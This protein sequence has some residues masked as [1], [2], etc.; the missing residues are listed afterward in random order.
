MLKVCDP[1][2]PLG[3]VTV[4][5]PLGLTASPPMVNVAVICVELTTVTFVI[6]IASAL[7]LIVVW[8]AMKFVPVS[9]TPTAVPAIPQLGLSP[10]SVGAPAEAELT[11]NVTPLLVPPAVVTLTLCPPTG[12][13]AVMANVAVT[14]VAVATTL[15]TVMPLS[16]L[17]VAPV[18]LVPVSVTVVMV[19]PWFP[20][21]GLMVLSV[22]AGGGG[23]FTVSV[24]PLLVPPA[25]IT[26]T[27][28]PPR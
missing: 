28:C 9:V 2:V 4:I 11:V 3:V 1:L 12:A 23:T 7:E 14:C 17:I 8:P 5:R 24:T 13:P 20:L 16:A 18:R 26:V 21:V 19:C 27:L 6:M 10:V 15:L 22:G 25:V